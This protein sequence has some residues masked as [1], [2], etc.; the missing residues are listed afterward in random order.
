M[1]ADCRCLSRTSWYQVSWADVLSLHRHKKHAF[2]APAVAAPTFT[3]LLLLSC[4]V[5]VIR[6]LKWGSPQ[7][8]T[9]ALPEVSPCNSLKKGLK[10]FLRAPIEHSHSVTWILLPIDTWS[11]M[12][13]HTIAKWLHSPIFKPMAE[14][15]SSLHAERYLVRSKVTFSLISQQKVAT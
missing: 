2:A 9:A 8:Y 15:T 12:I 6:E 1:A 7:V 10:S 4:W 5:R 3:T 14:P 13:V 11:F